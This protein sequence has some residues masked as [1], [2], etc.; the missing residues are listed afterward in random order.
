MNFQPRLI[1]AAFCTAAI[2][3]ALQAAPAAAAE[4]LIP[5]DN[6]AVNQYTEG[7][8]T[9]GG[10]RDAERRDDVPRPAETIGAKTTNQLQQAGPEGEAAALVAAETAPPP[11]AEGQA[12]DSGSRAKKNGGAGGGGSRPSAEPE[13]RPPLGE[14]AAAST[15]TAGGIGLLLP[16]VIVA[17]LAWGIGHAWRNRSGGT[18]GGS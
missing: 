2:V 1:G 18:A 14:L 10:E 13:G 5:E 3:L 16:L 9:G 6:S 12:D 17:T 15:G 8:P 4:Y 7:L 11:S